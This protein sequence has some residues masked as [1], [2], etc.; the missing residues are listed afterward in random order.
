MKSP[1]CN[2]TDCNRK[3]YC[4]GLCNAHYQQQS[5]GWTLTR[6]KQDVSIIERFWSKVQKTETCW[7]W[8]GGKNS[9]GYGSMRIGKDSILAH[10]FSYELHTGIKLTP[11]QQ[12]DHKYQECP[13][14]NCVNPA[15]LEIVSLEE[16]VAR[17][18]SLRLMHKELIRLRKLL[19]EN[20]IN[21]DQSPE[22]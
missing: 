21:P 2:F 14:K 5:K 11:E 10:R 1:L 18:I 9:K 12:L 8:T 15:H 16:N 22:Y 19:I 6:L 17:K 4:M 13:N 3:E 20:G 7:L